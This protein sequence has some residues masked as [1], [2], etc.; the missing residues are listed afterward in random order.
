LEAA[1]YREKP[2]LRI[3]PKCQ[4]HTDLKGGKLLPLEELKEPGQTKQ[5]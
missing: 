3:L 2:V 5:Y 1:L 4:H